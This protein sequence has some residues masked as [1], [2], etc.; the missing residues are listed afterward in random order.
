VV[1]NNFDL[2]RLLFAAVVC[3]VHVQALPGFAELSG[4][5]ALLSSS[6]AVK[7]FFVV[8]GYLIFMSFDKSTSVWSY[9]KKRV[10]RI[11]PAY[12]T[13]VVLCALGLFSVSR[14]TWSEYFSIALV[15]YLIA[16]LTFLNFLKQDLPG[17]FDR[18]AFN[19][20][21]GALWTL[22]IEVLFYISVPFFVFFF[23]KFGVFKWLIIFY[24]L[25][26]AYALLC[27]EL[28]KR[29]GSALY[30]E[31]SRQLP[32][33]LSYFFSGAFYY[34]F[35]SRTEPF[36]AQL[37]WTALFVLALNFYVPV[38]LLEPF[39]LATVVIFIATY[40]YWGNFGRYGDFSFGL[41][42]LH[43]PLIQL[44]IQQG[45]LVDSPWLFLL[46]ILVVT[47]FGAIAMWHLVEKHFLSR[48]SHYMFATS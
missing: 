27:H 2:L 42:I 18:N 46:T 35:S 6:V 1:A 20:V 19:A 13:V 38:P 33:Q 21:N 17:V 31:L 48:S 3:V 16:N 22:K 8:S 32:G 7:A 23:R 34:F 29:T 44:W 47:A 10:R 39:A 43:F 28:A 14:V 26:I 45:W 36:R 15:K 30:V 11:Y 12:V 40:R 4:L 24:L 37:F 5:T 9:A 41:Y 25:S